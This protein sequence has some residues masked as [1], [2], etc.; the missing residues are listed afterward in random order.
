MYISLPVLFIFV[1]L[2]FIRFGCYCSGKVGLPAI[3]PTP[4]PAFSHN[5][6]PF[7][8][9][10]LLSNSKHVVLMVTVHHDTLPAAKGRCLT[11]I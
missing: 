6:S 11:L 8:G 9:E 2:I 3:V 1:F 7:L 5:S 4:I 10:Q